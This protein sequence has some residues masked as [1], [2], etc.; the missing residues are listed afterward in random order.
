MV[1]SQKKAKN[2][3]Q[4]TETVPATVDTHRP[5]P[6][7]PSVVLRIQGVHG[8][9]QGLGAHGQRPVVTGFRG[10]GGSG[11]DMDLMN[12]VKMEMVRTC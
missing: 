10:R 2:G 4:K 11:C 3:Q 9:P 5:V 12:F 7:D 6:S 8:L 1:P